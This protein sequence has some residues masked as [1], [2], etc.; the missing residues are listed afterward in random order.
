[1]GT[2]AI[3][4]VWSRFFPDKPFEFNF[5]DSVFDKTYKS[6]N[7][8]ARIFGLFASL[9][10][11]ISCLGLSGL[12]AHIAATRRKE[13]GIRKVL[14]ASVTGIVKLL[15]KEFIILIILGWVIAFPVAWWAMNKW[16]QDF[17]YRVTI[18]WWIFAAAG[19]AAI[20][21]ALITVSLQAVK[22]A[23]ANPVNSLRSE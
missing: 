13:I 6:E 22:A 17:A 11:L 23:V 9:A 3:K 1:M 18:S 8:T 7:K 5:L 4:K 14:G 15:A 12:I 16:L 2:E 19:A 10:I 20:S 21:I